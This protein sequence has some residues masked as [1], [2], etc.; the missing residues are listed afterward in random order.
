[1]TVR[2]FRS[3]LFVG[4]VLNEHLTDMNLT[5]ADSSGHWP[6]YTSVGVRKQTA[7]LASIVLADAH[8][9]PP[10]AAQT[11]HDAGASQ[12]RLPRDLVPVS[13]NSSHSEGRREPLVP[14]A[15]ICPSSSP[16]LS[17]LFRADDL[18]KSP[19]LAPVAT[20]MVRKDTGVAAAAVTEW[21]LL[22]P[23]NC[24]SGDEHAFY[25][26]AEP[27]SLQDGVESQHH[28]AESLFRRSSISGAGKWLGGDGR[29][30]LRRLSPRRRMTLRDVWKRGVV[31]PLRLLPSVLLGLLLNVLDGLSYGK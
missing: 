24:G 25:G 12:M 15:Y 16:N 11:L 29:H 30:V 4:F 31:Q 22:L 19:P 1:M 23:K 2:V 14:S 8:G 21:D 10:Q 5:A 26:A 28:R 13:Q 9:T 17:G 18:T 27:A 20:H 6:H 7:E 3:S